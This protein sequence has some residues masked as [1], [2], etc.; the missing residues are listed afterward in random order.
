M[1]KLL[2]GIALTLVFGVGGL[3]TLLVLFGA[4]RM[5]E[6]TPLLTFLAILGALTWAALRVS[7]MRRESLKANPDD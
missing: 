6:L 5:G 7:R 4:W 1:K 2:D 3:F